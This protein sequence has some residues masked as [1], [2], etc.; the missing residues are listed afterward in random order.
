MVYGTQPSTFQEI[1]L[2][3]ASAQN[4]NGSNRHQVDRGVSDYG[5]IQTP[6]DV[7]YDISGLKSLTRFRPPLVK[8]R[9]QYLVSMTAILNVMSPGL[10]SF[11]GNQFA[12]M[13]LYIL[14]NY[15]PSIKVDNMNVC[16]FDML[17]CV[18]YVRFSMLHF[19]KLKQLSKN[20]V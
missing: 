5:R 15:S 9:S 7:I 2:R 13:T 10:T 16:S 20:T 14:E 17:R 6:S 19:S 12:V 3:Q 4:E 11:F 18:S 8:K 1:H